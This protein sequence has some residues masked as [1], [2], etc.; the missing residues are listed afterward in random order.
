M[1]FSM[2]ARAA[3]E[4][5]SFFSK[6]GGGTKLGLKVVDERVT[7]I[8]DPHDPEMRGAP[9]TNEGMPTER[10]V[11]I[12]KGVVK[13]LSYDRYWAQKK[14]MPSTRSPGSIRMSGGDASIP[15]LIANV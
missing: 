10:V 6:D 3:D 9:F 5:R 2:N 14:S 8:S 1:M 11:W 13:A 7:I 12:E 4:G 15:Q